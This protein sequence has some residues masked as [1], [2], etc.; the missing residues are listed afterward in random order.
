M[1]IIRKQ[2]INKIE[3]RATLYKRD[4][5]YMVNNCAVSRITTNSSIYIVVVRLA[6]GHYYVVTGEQVNKQCNWFLND[7][8][9]QRVPLNKITH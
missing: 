5:D 7:W 2:L 6:K 3:N 1:C 9:P 8:Y 4:I